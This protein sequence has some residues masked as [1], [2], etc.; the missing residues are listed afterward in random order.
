MKKLKQLSR[1]EIKSVSGA[2]GPVQDPISD[3]ECGCTMAA[4]VTGSNKDGSS[5]CSNSSCC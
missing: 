1:K 3:V 4:C 2:K 5:R